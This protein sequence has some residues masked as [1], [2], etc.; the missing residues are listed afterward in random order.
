MFTPAASYVA[1]D[2]EVTNKTCEC[3]RFSPRIYGTFRSPAARPMSEICSTIV[4]SCAKWL[5]VVWQIGR[6]LASNIE[7]LI[8]I[9]FLKQQYAWPF[10]SF[11]LFVLRPCGGTRTPAASRPEITPW[12]TRVQCRAELRTSREMGV[13]RM[14]DLRMSYEPICADMRRELRS[15]EVADIGI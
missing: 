5:F 1:V 14:L 9:H 13:V 8:L 4:L 3:Q 7:A 6:A 10:L 12:K 11:G 15:I 2:L